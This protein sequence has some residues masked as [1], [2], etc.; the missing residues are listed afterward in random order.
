MV[1]AVKETI[2]EVA[3][4]LLPLAS[5]SSSNTAISAVF[6]VAKDDAEDEITNQEKSLLL[7]NLNDLLD[8]PGMKPNFI[9]ALESKYF[10]IETIVDI[11]VAKTKKQFF[12]AM[13]FRCLC[14]TIYTE[15]FL[16]CV[17]N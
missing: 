3:P 1:G 6:P 8:L 12:R 10:T 14:M 9:E 2:K 5:T 11:F 17:D 13:E 16:M 7:S 15:Y 4:I